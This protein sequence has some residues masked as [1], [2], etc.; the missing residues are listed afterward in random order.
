MVASKEMQDPFQTLCR[1][2]SLFFSTHH[3]F[4]MTTHPPILMATLKMGRTTL[5]LTLCACLGT[6]QHD[7][8]LYLCLTTFQLRSVIRQGRLERG[9]LIRS[10][11]FSGGGTKKNVGYFF[12]YTRRK[13]LFLVCTVPVAILNECNF[14]V[15]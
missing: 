10:V 11:K 15:S 5:L 4:L 7:L 1:D 3:I 2:V 14:Y 6:L 13:D 12:I 8:D 9:R